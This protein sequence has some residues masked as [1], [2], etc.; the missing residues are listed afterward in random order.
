[1]TKL[2]DMQVKEFMDTLASKEPTP[3]GGSASALAGGMAASL[4]IM[5]GNLT[6]GRK[7]YRNLSEDDQNELDDKYEKLQAAKRKLEGLVDKDKEAFDQLMAAFKMPKETDTEKEQRKR[8]IQ[9]GTQRALDVPLETAQE[10]L[11]VLHYLEVFARNGNPNA[12]TDVGVGA[13]MAQTAME[14]ALYNVEINLM[15]V[16]DESYKKE[17]RQQKEKMQVEGNELKEKIESLVY[18]RM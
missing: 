16:A 8:A 9:E 1:M 10:C 11:E 2:I 13:L 18:E 5:V 17:L 7:R 6:I 15:D 3:G 14:G 12:I 4:G